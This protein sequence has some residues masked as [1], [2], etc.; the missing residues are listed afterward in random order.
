MEEPELLKL[1][2]EDK[3]ASEMSAAKS[4]L[5][6]REIGLIV[7]VIVAILG[8]TVYAL[9]MGKGKGGE[10][11][12]FADCVAAGNPVMESYPEQCMGG[13]L[14]WTNPDQ[15]PIEQ[16][17]DESP[18]TQPLLQGPGKYQDAIKPFAITLPEGWSV[19]GRA[20]AN[21][22][23]SFRSRSC[24]ASIEVR[25]YTH[26]ASADATIEDIDADFLSKL[27][28]Y[29]TN[30][31]SG[32]KSHQTTKLTLAGK[33]ALKVR[34]VSNA[35]AGQYEDTEEIYYTVRMNS[36]NRL[37]IQYDRQPAFQPNACIEDFDKIALSL[38]LL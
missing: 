22:V 9:V 8:V 2:P 5:S 7:F 11:R 36:E 25:T 1:V 29:D 18:E 21:E 26:S 38:E 33:P 27:T 23:V 19:Y 12:S 31:P 32:Y 24:D 35:A 15:A 20:N 3:V 28:G 17:E 34:Q 6:K 13:G 30:P 10:I 4:R 16:S 14:T 37:H